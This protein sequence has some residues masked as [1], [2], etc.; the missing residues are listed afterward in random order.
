MPRSAARAARMKAR[1]LSGSFSPGARSTPDDTSTPRRLGDRER[2]GDI[3]G[4]EAARQHEIDRRVD[5]LEQRPVEGLPSPPG[6]VA[7]ARRARIEQQAVGD[8]A[9]SMRIGERSSRCAIGSAFITGRPKRERTTAT[10]SGVSLPCSCSMSGFSASTMLCSVSSLASTVS[11]T[12]PARP[13]T[14]APTPAGGLEAEVARAR[15][16]EHEADQVGAGF[17]RDFKS[18]RRSSGRKF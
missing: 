17:Q 13:S 7:S 9:Q 16:K 1:I 8:L 4:I 3:R 5:A 10:R 18:F 12:L 14:C 6:R 11:A 15:R 2:L